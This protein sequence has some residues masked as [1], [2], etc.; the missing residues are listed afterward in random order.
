MNRTSCLLALAILSGF[1]LFAYAQTTPQPLS[2]ES[3]GQLLLAA[4]PHI[5]NGITWLLDNLLKA[6]LAFLGAV[7]A[8]LFMGLPESSQVKRK[9]K[10]LWPNSGNLDRAVALILI[11]VGTLLALVILQPGNYPSALYA[12]LSWPAVLVNVRN[13]LRRARQAPTSTDQTSQGA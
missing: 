11:L 4:L 8:Y 10:K 12:G 5:W 3:V 9:L 1:S 2:L 13:Y 7:I 6:V